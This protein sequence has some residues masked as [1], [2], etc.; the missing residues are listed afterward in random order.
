[1]KN[2]TYYKFA[3]AKFLKNKPSD[4]DMSILR[5]R[6]NY[7]IEFP[8]SDEESTLANAMREENLFRRYGTVIENTTNPEG[9]I[10]VSNSTAKAGITKEGAL[11]PNTNKDF[12]ET[13]FG[14]HK[15]GLLMRVKKDF[16][17]DAGF[18]FQ[19]YA[20]TEFGKR[21]GRAEEDIGLNGTGV[22]QPKGLL[23]TASVGATASA[24]TYDAIIKL[25]FSVSAEHRKNSV[26]VMNDETAYVL[27]SLKDANGNY[28]WNTTN[29]TILGKQVVISNYMADKSKPVVFGDLSYFWTIIRRPLALRI[30]EE[31]YAGY[32]EY[33]YIAHERLDFKLVRSD[34]VKVLK[35][36]LEEVMAQ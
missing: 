10:L 22:D 14:S 12:T 4:E 33:G 17:N 18:D 32:D 36:D 6:D 34:A 29:D 30:L 24:L 8:R 27:R 25:Y 19:D 28:L 1:M 31:T 11:F 26:F 35:L 2:T 16:V 20:Y 13:R 7:D 23:H 21:F 15:L 9:T 3:F 5:M